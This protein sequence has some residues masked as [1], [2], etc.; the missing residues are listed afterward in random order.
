MGLGRFPSYKLNT[1]RRK[2]TGTQYRDTSTLPKVSSQDTF[3][4]K[5]SEKKPKKALDQLLL[6]TITVLDNME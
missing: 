3:W 4:A 6:M 1:N 5:K 2:Y